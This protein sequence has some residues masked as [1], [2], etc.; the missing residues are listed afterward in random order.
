[1]TDSDSPGTSRVDSEELPREKLEQL[2]ELQRNLLHQVALSDRQTDILENLCRAAEKIIDGS[3]TSV[4]LRDG[5]AQMKVRAAPSLPP[6]VVNFLD[7]VEFGLAPCHQAVLRE[8]PVFIQNPDGLENWEDVDVFGEGR[9][10]ASCWSMPIIDTMG[11]VFGSFAILGPR[12]STPNRFQSLL[13]ESCAYIAAIVVERTQKD[14]SLY[15]QAHRD[16][17]TGL[18]NRGL[19][20]IRLS[21][22]LVDAEEQNRHL[23]LMFIDIDHFKRM[24]DSFGHMV[25]DDLI[26]QVAN[27]LREGLSD[28]Q[29]L[30]RIGG[31]EFILLCSSP[32][33]DRQQLQQRAESVMGLIAQPIQ[34]NGREFVLSASIG[35]SRFPQDAKLD[36]T[37]LQSADSALFQAKLH[38][39]NT[40]V[41]YQPSYTAAAQRVT[42]VEAELRQA[43]SKGEI[44]PFFQPQIDCRNEA[45]HGFEV[46]ARW[47]HPARG[48]I[49]A[50]EFIGIAQQTGLITSLGR[51][52]LKAALDIFERLPREQIPNVKLALNATVDELL[53]G[54]VEYLQQLLE[55]TSL[56]AGDL[57]VEILEDGFMNDSGICADAM[58]KLERMGVSICL[59]DFG[60]GYSSL[61]R[62]RSFPVSKIKID[63]SFVADIGTESGEQLV[64][65]I[66]G[67]ADSLLLEVVAEGSETAEQS[68]LLCELGCHTHQG[69]Y[70]ARPMSEG[71]LLSWLD[72]RQQQGAP[73]DIR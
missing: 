64:K 40:F 65:A 14:Q 7:S 33:F 2:V 3:R 52:V 4:M 41:F 70:R 22:E 59:D 21:Q 44:V 5:L 34:S 11:T 53:H 36:T 31:D 45:V 24:N 58:S 9:K 61:S 54:Y 13:L 1:M 28:D 72:T 12:A 42:E 18:P 38:G 69:Y 55:G 43:M 23:A 17:L 16:S 47:R 73:S 71:D 25:G 6:T 32:G 50:S 66:I 49:P 51:V 20:D 62:L 8:S 48:L 27:R 35:I 29:F 30:A 39:R 56:N 19:F 26:I 57:E 67:M 15:D 10:V 63:K 37:L 68:S 60:I 46:L